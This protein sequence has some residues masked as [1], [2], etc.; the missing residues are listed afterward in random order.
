MMFIEA[1]AGV[2]FS[3]SDTPSDLVTGDAKTAKDN[4]AAIREFLTRFPE[5]VGRELYIARCRVFEK[6][7]KNPVI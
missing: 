7:S 1:P 3:Y 6:T 2:G 5:L 4:L